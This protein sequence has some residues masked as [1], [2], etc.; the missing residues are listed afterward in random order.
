MRRSLRR[1]LAPT[2]AP[3]HKEEVIRRRWPA[4]G[5]ALAALQAEAVPALA[6][7]HTLALRGA[8]DRLPKKKRPTRPFRFCLTHVRLLPF[9][10]V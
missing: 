7:E 3:W 5:A 8:A 4:L 6:A 2:A 10:F 9:C 1:G